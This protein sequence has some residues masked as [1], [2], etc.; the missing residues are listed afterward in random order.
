M[1]RPQTLRLRRTPFAGRTS[2][3]WKHIGRAKKIWIDENPTLPSV[4][5]WA[6]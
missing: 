3:D 2:N 1:D 6:E 5:G 4:F